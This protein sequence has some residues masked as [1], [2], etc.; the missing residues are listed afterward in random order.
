M[1]INYYSLSETPT[2]KFQKLIDTIYV[3]SSMKPSVNITTYHDK[4]FVTWITV[5]EEDTCVGRLSILK[6]SDIQYDHHPVLLIG[7]VELI[8]NPLVMNLLNEE[9]RKFTAQYKNH[10]IIGPVNGTTWDSYRLVKPP[11]QPYFFLDVIHPGYYYDLFSLTGWSPIESYISTEGEIYQVNVDEVLSIGKRYEE[12]GISILPLDMSQF[13]KEVKSIFELCLISFKSNVLYSP[14][15]WEEFYD[16]YQKVKPF[17]HSDYVYVAKDK[18]KTIGFIFS[19]PDIFSR[20]K[21]RLIIKTLAID[22][23]PKYKGLG[24]FLTRFLYVHAQHQFS[25]MIH[26]LMHNSN[27]SAFILAK[28]H[29]IIQHY[30]L[31]QLT[32]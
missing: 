25:H 2:D 1:K 13:E 24:S 12:K 6:N 31:F 16:K 29:H 10:L 3:S 26:A 30:D 5:F 4:Y 8:N 22:P 7:Y 17:I 27:K 21:K 32:K 11:I 15:S 9:I 19:I 14:I 23:S 28:N 18:G 20:E